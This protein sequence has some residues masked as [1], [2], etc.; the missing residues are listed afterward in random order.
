MHSK[1]HQEEKK[2][3][4]K[5]RTDAHALLPPLRLVEKLSKVHSTSITAG[6]ALQP[7]LPPFPPSSSCLFVC[8]SFLSILRGSSLLSSFTKKIHATT[9]VHREERYVLLFVNDSD[10][11]HLMAASLV[12]LS[13][14]IVS[15]LCGRAHHPSHAGRRRARA[16]KTR[17]NGGDRLR[18][19]LGSFVRRLPTG[20]LHY[21]WMMMLC[22]AVYDVG[23]IT[24]PADGNECPSPIN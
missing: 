6:L 8:Y 5:S 16:I 2:R 18:G 13:L 15:P 14:I 23:R 4:R 20:S 21:C 7:S 3:H 10:S 22:A 24:H 17:L 1:V 19:I 12:A 11:R 9:I